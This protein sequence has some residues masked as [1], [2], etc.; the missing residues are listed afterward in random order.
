MALKE[1]FDIFYGKLILAEAEVKRWKRGK[2][3]S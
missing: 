1:Q 2:P 3:S